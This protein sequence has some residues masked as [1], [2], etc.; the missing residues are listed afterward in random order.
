[1]SRRVISEYFPD[2]K[3]VLTTKQYIDGKL[4][5]EQLAWHPNGNRFYEHMYSSGKQ[6]GAQSQWWANGRL[7]QKFFFKNGKQ[8][9][10]QFAYHCNGKNYC[11]EIYKNGKLITRSEWNYNGNLE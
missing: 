6:D 1:M 9:G 4:E 2:N 7:M 11:R 5:G 8:E 3:Q 10:E